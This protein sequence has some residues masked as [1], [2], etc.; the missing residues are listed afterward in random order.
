MT[1]YCSSGAHSAHVLPLRLPGR[2]IFGD[3]SL[4]RAIATVP[5]QDAD[6]GP[7]LRMF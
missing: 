5:G 3:W 6:F 1:G 4:Q 2:A 7:R